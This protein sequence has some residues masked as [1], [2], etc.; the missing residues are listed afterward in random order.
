MALSTQ[1]HTNIVQSLATI[2]HKARQEHNILFCSHRFRVDCDSYCQVNQPDHPIFARSKSRRAFTMLYKEPLVL[3]ATTPEVSSTP[4]KVCASKQKRTRVSYTTRNRCSSNK[5]KLASQSLVPLNV[6]TP[7][8]PHSK[9]GDLKLH[10]TRLLEFVHCPGFTNSLLWN[11]FSHHNHIGLQK[12]I[13][14]VKRKAMSSNS[15]DFQLESLVYNAIPRRLRPT[16]QEELDGFCE[17]LY[18]YAFSQESA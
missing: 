13:Q 12:I 3:R 5:K 18:D 1:L 17:N 14:E 16:T 6:S 11:Y 15:S 2:L 4:D 9:A 7:I 8:R 10:G